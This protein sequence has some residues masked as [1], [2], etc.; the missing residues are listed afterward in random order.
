MNYL[1]H[2][3][4]SF[5]H[6]ELLT[7]NMISDF[8]KGK[9]KFTYPPSIQQGIMLHRAIDTLT[10]THEATREAKEIFRPHYRLYSGAFVDVVYDHFLATDSTEFSEQSLLDFSQQVYASLDK[11]VEWLP[12]RF[13]GM[14]PFMKE[15]N[16]LFHYRTRWG[17]GKSLGGVVRRAAYLTESETAF[18]LFEEHYQLLGDCY[19]HFWASVKPFARNQFEMLQKDAGITL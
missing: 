5:G 14:F 3:Y 18:Q 12:E 16:W 15:H 6:P 1:A 2:A 7:G 17:T 9:K 13:A 4:L 8:V 10:D 11:Q 19:R